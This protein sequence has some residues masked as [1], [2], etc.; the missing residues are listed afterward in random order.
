MEAQ[1]EKK[2]RNLIENE[3][4]SVNKLKLQLNFVAGSIGRRNKEK[5]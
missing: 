1:F 2:P 5:E 4:L 3:L